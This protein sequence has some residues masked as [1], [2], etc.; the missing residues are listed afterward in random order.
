[1]IANTVS[2]SD[3]F[4]KNVW[5]VRF[6]LPQEE[7]RTNSDFKLVKLDKLVSERRESVT[8]TV[9]DEGVN[10]IGLENI[11]AKTGRIASF[12]PKHGE[13][14]KSTCKR[15]YKGDILYGRLR[16]TL[17]K[18]YYND[19][20]KEGV[21]TTEILVLSP[22]LER[23]NP[24]YL[25]ELLR[26]EVINRRIVGLIKGAA[27]PRIAMA[28]LKQIA[29]PI[30]SLE[31]QNEIANEILRKR[32]ELEEHIRLAQEIPM[33]IDKYLTDAYK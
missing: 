13:E 28:D 32:K 20:F 24:I 21:C 6:F 2:S 18:V 5:S 23:V 17:N 33:D 4:L 1:M 26:T 16:P 22:T 29:L 10:Y 15:F 31:R 27:L 25:A 7:L 3:L 9:E 11:E 30:P 8:L 14:I 19:C 12:V